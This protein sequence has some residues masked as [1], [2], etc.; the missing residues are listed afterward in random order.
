MN[1]KFALCNRL[2]IYGNRLPAVIERFNSNFKACNRLHTYCNRLPKEIFRKYSQLSHLFIWFLNGYQRPIYMW[3][4]TRIWKKFF[5]TKR[6]YPLKK[7]NC[8]I[9]LQIPWPKHLWFNKELF[10]CSNCSIYLFQERFLL[11][12]FFILKRD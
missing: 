1:S 6:S 12:F 8:F 7:Q 3:L 5:R 2:H 9:L 4:E 11:L 10:E